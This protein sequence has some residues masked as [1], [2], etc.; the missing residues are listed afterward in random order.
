MLNRDLEKQLSVE[1]TDPVRADVIDVSAGP[2]DSARTAPAPRRESVPVTPKPK[3]GRMVGLSILLLAIG[4]GAG[5]LFHRQYQ[6]K[7]D[8]IVAVDGVIIN[9]GELFNRMEKAAG[10]D[11][12]RQLVTE[13]IQVGYA[14]E[15]GVLPSNETVEEAVKAALS[16]PTFQRQIANSGES[17][18]DYSREVQVNLAKAAVVTQGITVTEDDI[19]AYYEDNIRH[20]NQTARFYTPETVTLQVIRNHNQAAIEAADHDLRNGRDFSAVVADYSTDQSKS[21]GGVSQPLIRGRNNMRTVPGMEDAVFG[22]NIGDTLGPRKFAGDWWIFKCVDKSP[23]ETIPYERA[24][25]EA[26]IGAKM[27]KVTPQRMSAVQEDFERYEKGVNLQVFW[28][29]YQDSLVLH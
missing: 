19:K 23:A 17:V 1:N 6:N 10:R 16:D 5:A 25:I 29:K 8:T 26:E 27:A 12:L 7:K 18:E 11:A 9:K 2:G 13:Q 3:R 15:R 22:I 24:H 21:N 14:K 28:Q 4:F 20:D